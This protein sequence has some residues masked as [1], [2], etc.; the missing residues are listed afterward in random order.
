M[1]LLSEEITTAKE[2]AEVIIATT[3]TSI[4]VI[5]TETIVAVVPPKGET[6]AAKIPAD[7]EEEP[8]LVVGDEVEAEGITVEIVGPN[9]VVVAT[10]TV[11]QVTE[12]LE[13]GATALIMSHKGV[14]MPMP[15]PQLLPR[16][17][18]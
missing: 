1:V 2:E 15:C 12:I 3:E 10:I 13:S 7:E 6:V 17:T 9:E 11:L 4:S 16:S 18:T 8:G 14:I 5:E